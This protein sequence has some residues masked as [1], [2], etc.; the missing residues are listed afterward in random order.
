MEKQAYDLVKPLKEFRV[1][2]LNSHNTAYVISSSE[3]DI[4]PQPNPE[5]KR[6]K[7]IALLL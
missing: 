7:W 4:L 2:I 5:G 3:K 1:Y 6:G